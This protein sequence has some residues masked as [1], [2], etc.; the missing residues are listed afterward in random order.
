MALLQEIFKEAYSFAMRRS[1]A[2]STLAG[3]HSAQLGIGL[4]GRLSPGASGDI[5]LRL[6][7]LKMLTDPKRLSV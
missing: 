2:L 5:S 4:T 6:T 1:F 7:C 3:K